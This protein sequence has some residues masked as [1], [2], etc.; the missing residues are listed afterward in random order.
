MPDY[1]EEAKLEGRDNA[2]TDSPNVTADGPLSFSVRGNRDAVASFIQE[3]LPLLQEQA[4]TNEL[5]VT[6]FSS[7]TN[8]YY[9]RPSLIMQE[10]VPMPDA[11]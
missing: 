8:E 1:A 3:V 9:N 7:Y 10:S 6:S 2:E 4:D 11:R 5:I